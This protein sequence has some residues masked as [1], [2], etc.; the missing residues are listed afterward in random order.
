M[1]III[2]KIIQNIFLIDFKIIEIFFLYIISI[3]K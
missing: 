3:M 1:I 2:E